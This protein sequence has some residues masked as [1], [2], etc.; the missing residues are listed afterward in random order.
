MN[1]APFHAAA[2]CLGLEGLPGGL[3][4]VKGAVWDGLPSR[5]S[6]AQRFKG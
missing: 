5:R 3:C 1:A 2:V 6:W 4:E